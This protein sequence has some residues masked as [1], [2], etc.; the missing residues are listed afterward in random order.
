M[1]NLEKRLAVQV[2]ELWYEEFLQKEHE[3]I[4][5]QRQRN[6][7]RSIAEATYYGTSVNFLEKHR[8]QQKDSL[9]LNDYYHRRM[10]Y[11]NKDL[12]NPS[13]S[14]KKDQDRIRKELHDFAYNFSRPFITKLIKC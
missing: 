9:E 2:E 10:T 12:L 7:Q 11:Y 6:L 1:Y 4:E 5:Q 14:S 8:K 3:A 13:F